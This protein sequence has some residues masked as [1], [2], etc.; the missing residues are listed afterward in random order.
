M[1][2]LRI[3]NIS[4]AGVSVISTVIVVESKSLLGLFLNSPFPS[5]LLFL[6][7]D[8]YVHHHQWCTFVT[9][10][11]IFI[12]TMSVI[13]CYHVALINGYRHPQ[14]SSSSLSALLLWV[15]NI[16]QALLGTFRSVHLFILIIIIT[17]NRHFSHVI[18]NIIDHQQIT[19]FALIAMLC[20]ILFTFITTR[21]RI[22]LIVT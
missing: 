1:Q 20:W 3:I 13:I 6:T 2:S 9:I 5:P 18:S 15:I 11:I 14:Q 22:S 12:S 17:I 7:H 10:N 21:T 4:P 16:N 19:I 8:W